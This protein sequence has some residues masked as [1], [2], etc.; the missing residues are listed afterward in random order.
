LPFSHHPIPRRPNPPTQQRLESRAYANSLSLS[1]A[2]C[3][4]LV[5][6]QCSID[7]RVK[8]VPNMLSKRL[9]RTRKPR[10]GRTTFC[11]GACPC[12]RVFRRCGTVRR[13]HIGQFVL[14]RLEKWKIRKI[15]G[16]FTHALHSMSFIWNLRTTRQRLS[17]L[18]FVMAL[19]AQG[20][21][22]G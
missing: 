3:G 10:S 6:T 14:G 16:A 4:T 21:S 17:G 18:L 2:Y 19:F 5:L 15:K 13:M 11:R 1:P 7:V 9:F 12:S 20:A 22:T 8:L